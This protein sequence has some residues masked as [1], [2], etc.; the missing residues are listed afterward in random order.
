MKEGSK[1]AKEKHYFG[2]NKHEKA[3]L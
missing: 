3:L 2:K 1:E